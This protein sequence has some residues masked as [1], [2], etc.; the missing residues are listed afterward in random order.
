MT[1]SMLSKLE[2]NEHRKQPV[3]I[4]GNQRIKLCG[5]EQILIMK[6][7]LN[8]PLNISQIEYSRLNYS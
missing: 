3:Y 8:S 5:P 7:T 4:R 2:L 6:T 1:F